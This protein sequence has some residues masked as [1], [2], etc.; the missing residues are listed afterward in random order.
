MASRITD[1]TRAGRPRK[2]DVWPCTTGGAFALVI[3][4]C[5]LVF[6]AVGIAIAV[7]GHS[8]GYFSRD[9]AA[10]LGAHPAVGLLSHVGV[11]ILWGTATTCLISSAYIGQFRPWRPSDVLFVS[12][13]GTAWLALDDLFEV[14]EDLLSRIG[15]G[16]ATVVSVYAVA[17]VV[18]LWRYRDVIRAYEWPLL[19]TAGAALAGSLVV[20]FSGSSVLSGD[21]ARLVEEGLKLLGYTLLAAYFVRL[22]VLMHAATARVESSERA[23]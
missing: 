1:A 16:E 11:L 20:D 4:V 18:F 3:A 22:A 21:G 8:F 17:T 2:P 13:L 23:R 9:P 12:G 10:S 15:V 7:T 14:H 6:L 5:L 19:A